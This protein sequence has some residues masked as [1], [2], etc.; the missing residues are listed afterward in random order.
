[1]PRS[2]AVAFPETH[3]NEKPCKVRVS[4]NVRP[5]RSLEELLAAADAAAETDQATRARAA[6][7][8]ISGAASP[9]GGGGERYP[10]RAVKSTTMMVDGHVVLKANNYDLESGMR[11]V[12]DT[13]ELNKDTSSQPL[14]PPRDRDSA[15]GDGKKASTTKPADKKPK[16]APRVLSAAEQSRLAHNKSVGAHAEVDELRRAVFLHAHLPVGGGG[17]KLKLADPWIDRRPVSDND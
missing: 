2:Q 1:M 5:W 7:A 15:P 12:F 16:P 17:C 13:G 6:A 14:A 9:E 4:T 10:R 3:P 11:S 8:E